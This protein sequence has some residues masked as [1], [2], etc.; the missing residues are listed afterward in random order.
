MARNRQAH[1]RR[2]AQEGSNEAPRSHHF[3]QEACGGQEG[4]QA[5]F[6][7]GLQAEEG[8]LQADAQVDGEVVSSSLAQAWRVL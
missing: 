8:H 5:P 3:A 7:H 2:L 1:I 6:L 4:H